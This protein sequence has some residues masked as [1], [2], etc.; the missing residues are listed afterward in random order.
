MKR[1]LLEGSGGSS[2]LVAGDLETPAWGV[3]QPRVLE[4][5]QR[6]GPLQEEHGRPDDP[7]GPYFFGGFH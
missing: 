3:L 7:G 4:V 6:R 1:V 2:R 5:L